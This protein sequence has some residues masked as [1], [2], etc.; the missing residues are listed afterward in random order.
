MY[1]FEKIGSTDFQVTFRA[2]PEQ[3]RCPY[4][5]NQR[6]GDKQ[7]DIDLAVSSA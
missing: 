3:P 6:A 5:A 7:A 2:Q 1:C 4:V